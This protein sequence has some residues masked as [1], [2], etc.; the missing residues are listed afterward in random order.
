MSPLRLC[1][2]NRRETKKTTGL[3]MA[4]LTQVHKGSNPESLHVIFVHGLGG[5]AQSTWMHNPA[6]HTTLWPSWIGEDV[7]CHVWVAGYGAALSGWT[8]AA[9]H[10]TDLGE[11]LFAA[12]QAE[13]SLQGSRLVL[14]GHSLGGLVIKSGMT[15]AASLGDPRR[16]TLLNK[17]AGVVFV[18]TPHQ[19]SSLATVQTSYASS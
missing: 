7:G 18:A 11:A 6:D 19:G 16:M 5:E 15:Q 14:I 2:H 8:D 4:V 3:D 1:V 13:R 9:M 17:V 10:L 12:L